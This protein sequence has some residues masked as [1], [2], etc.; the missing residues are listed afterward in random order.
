MPNWRFKIDI[1]DFHTGLREGDISTRELAKGVA[2]RV[3]SSQAY[4][5]YFGDL[6][7]IAAEFDEAETLDEYDEALR[8]LY[9]F[10]DVEH[11]IWVNTLRSLIAQSK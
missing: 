4:V 3:R 7:D 2:E 5:I 6:E 1:S 11:R 9:D 10:A 8:R